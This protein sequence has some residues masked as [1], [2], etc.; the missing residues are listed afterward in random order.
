MKR[1]KAPRIQN[2][3]VCF[4]APEKLVIELNRLAKAHQ[5]TRS[6]LIRLMLV[7]AAKAEAG[8]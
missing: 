7:A 8:E 5:M 2:T 6:A 1:T 4:K 3:M